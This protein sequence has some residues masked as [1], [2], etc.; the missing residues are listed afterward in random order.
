MEESF[1]VSTHRIESRNSCQKCYWHF[2]FRYLEKSKISQEFIKKQRT[3]IGFKTF[4][5]FPKSI[6]ITEENQRLYYIYHP[7]LQRLFKEESNRIP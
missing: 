3:I 7:Y 6:V 2:E 4:S 1:C 5:R